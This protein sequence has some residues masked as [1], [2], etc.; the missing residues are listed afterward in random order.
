MASWQGPFDAAAGGREHVV[1]EC[2]FC[3]EETPP[4]WHDHVLGLHRDADTTMTPFIVVLRTTWRME[5]VS[6]PRCAR[7]HTGHQIERTAAV[8]S[9]AALIAYAASGQL[10]RLLG[11]LSSSAG[12]RVVAAV[13]AVVACLP[14]LAWI[15]I[16]LG[17]LP[18]QR[19]APRRLGY[20]RHHPEY[21]ELRADGWKPRADP[22]RYWR[23]PPNPHHPPPANRPRRLIGGS[24]ELL[25]AACGLAVPVAYFTGYEEL[26][27]VLIAATAGLLFVA[28]KIK[29][30]D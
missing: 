22:V 3:G 5:I 20:A 6:V 24:F 1:R 15:A 13:W 16:R 2:W 21:L 23:S 7:C 12:E 4:S 26:A 11:I 8:L 30:E 19:L 14:G 18:W 27:G 28:S 25:G 9:A 17:R 10:D 29:P